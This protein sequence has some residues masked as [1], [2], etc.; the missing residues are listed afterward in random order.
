MD[1]RAIAD[2]GPSLQLAQAYAM[3][4]F[5]GGRGGPAVSGYG[6]GGPRIDFSRFDSVMGAAAGVFPFAPLSYGG[7][8]PSGGLGFEGYAVTDTL[9]R[10]G[11]SY[12]VVLAEVLGA[13]RAH[14]ADRGW[15]EPVYTVG[16]EPGESSI[17]QVLAFADAIRAA[18]SR[19]SVFTSF[20]SPT[21]PRAAL[22]AHVDQVYLSHHSAASLQAILDQGHDCGTYNLGGRYARGLYQFVLR[23]LGCRAGF[24]QFAFNSSHG[25]MY[26]PL[27]GREDDL[28]AALPT[29]T[30]G[31]LVPTLDSERFRESIDD[32]RYLLALEQALEAPLDAQAAAEARAWLDGTLEDLRIGHTELANPPLNDADLDAL[33]AV[34]RHYILAVQ[35]LPTP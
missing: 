35:G 3:T 16:D 15:A 24:Y 14:V 22:A 10:Y 12:P 20:T 18:G 5:S 9:A 30:A 21:E 13:V 23:S 26:Y 8:A 1:A 2:L 7:L 6:A 29:A 19:T 25:D 31:T 32:Y 17:P 34:A 27:D 28:V 11:K 33:R 4:S